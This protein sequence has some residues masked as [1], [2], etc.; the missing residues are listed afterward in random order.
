MEM[1][2]SDIGNQ[3]MPK[4]EFWIPFKTTQSHIK[5]IIMQV[6]HKYQRQPSTIKLLSDFSF[7]GVLP[8]LLFEWHYKGSPL[9][10]YLIYMYI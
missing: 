2:L 6:I 3:K 1:I 8:G 4:E 5:I 9:I 7:K 10:V